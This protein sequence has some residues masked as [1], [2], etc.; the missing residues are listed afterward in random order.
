MMGLSRR[1]VMGGTTA[2][3]AATW[4][5][6]K[7]ASASAQPALQSSVKALV[8]DMFGTVVDW[9]NGVA[10]DA[11]RILQPLG[12]NL[13]WTAFADAWRSL[14]QPTMEEIRSGRQPFVKLDGAFV[15]RSAQAAL[16]SLSASRTASSWVCGETLGKTLAILPS[17]SMTKVARCTPM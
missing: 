2:I 14:Y 16:S 3:A 8:F 10:K 7:V 4:V 17:A 12:Y 15:V 1:G 5:A 9:R 13:D 11:E 6:G